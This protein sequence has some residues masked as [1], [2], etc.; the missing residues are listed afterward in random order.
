MRINTLLI[1]GMLLIIIMMLIPGFSRDIFQAGGEVVYFR[2]D[3]IDAVQISYLDDYNHCMVNL[4]NTKKMLETKR[5]LCPEVKCEC[6]QG[7]WGLLWTI[8]G[9]LMLIGGGIVYT[10]ATRKSEAIQKE[11]EKLEARKKMLIRINID[12]HKE[13]LKVEKKLKEAKRKCVQKK[14]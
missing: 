9:S 12:Y 3:Q 8:F 13:A 11:I 10:L 6:S 4:D 7:A 1:T 14:K 2:I 5:S